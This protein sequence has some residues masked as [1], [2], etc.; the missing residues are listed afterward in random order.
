MKHRGNR[1][2]KLVIQNRVPDSA[3]LHPGY[4]SNSVYGLH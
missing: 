4:R 1:D 3:K 2:A